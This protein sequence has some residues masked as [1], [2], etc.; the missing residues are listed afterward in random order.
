MFN[1]MVTVNLGNRLVQLKLKFGMLI[2]CLRTMHLY[3]K[4]NPEPSLIVCTHLFVNPHVT[5][6]FGMRKW[7]SGTEEYW[8]ERDRVKWG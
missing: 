4:E 6:C 2:V 8:T 7:L 5:D 3:A 1:L